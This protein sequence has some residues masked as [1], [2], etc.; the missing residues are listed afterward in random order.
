MIALEEAALEFDD[1]RL[2]PIAFVFEKRQKGPD[3]MRDLGRS[4]SGQR[5]RMVQQTS[6]KHTLLLVEHLLGDEGESAWEVLPI[7]SQLK[8]AGQRTWTLLPGNVGAE[9]TRWRLCVFD[10][11]WLQ[12][13]SIGM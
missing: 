7:H 9:K 8:L 13:I 5:C 10:F 1:G 4:E 12:S 2:L 11:V 3:A 6:N